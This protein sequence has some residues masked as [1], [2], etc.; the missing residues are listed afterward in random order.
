MIKPSIFCYGGKKTLCGCQPPFKLCYHVTWYRL[1]LTALVAYHCSLYTHRL[2]AR[3]AMSFCFW[4][5]VILSVCYLRLVLL[6]FLFILTVWLWQWWRKRRRSGWWWWGWW[7]GER[8]GWG[9]GGGE[10][11]VRI[12]VKIE[13]CWTAAS[14]AASTTITATMTATRTLKDVI[15]NF[16]INCMHHKL[17]AASTLTWDWEL[18]HIWHS[19]LMW[20]RETGLVLSLIK[21]KLLLF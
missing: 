16:S 7:E 18:N 4:L 3:R 9:G 1:C 21:L 17:T 10:I 15:L 20:Y 19:T 12:V 13:C 14:A 6:Q 5:C 2:E 11:G 8:R